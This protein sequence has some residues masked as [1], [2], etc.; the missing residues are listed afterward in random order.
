[1]RPPEPGCTLHLVSPS[2]L[3]TNG[4]RFETTIRRCAVFFMRIDPS[5]LES[6]A[7]ASCA[8]PCDNCTH[9]ATARASA[10]VLPAVG[11]P[12]VVRGGYESSRHRWPLT[13]SRASRLGG[14]PYRARPLTVQPRRDRA[15]P[16]WAGD[17]RRG[18][19][20]GCDARAM[21]AQAPPRLHPHAVE[22]QHRAP[23][24]K[25][26]RAPAAARSARAASAT[27]VPTGTIR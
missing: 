10:F 1:M 24:R 21:R 19:R 26:R 14:R 20:A 7:C 23:G 15:S 9:S 16:R 22:C 11:R 8:R 17:P 13:R 18:A 6:A 25:R 2:C 12:R 4:S 3:T 27:A 5:L